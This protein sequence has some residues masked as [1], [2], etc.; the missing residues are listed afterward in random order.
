[1][2]EIYLSLLIFAEAAAYLLMIYGLLA[3]VRNK[4]MRLKLTRKEV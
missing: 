1:M 3:I 4:L 2:N